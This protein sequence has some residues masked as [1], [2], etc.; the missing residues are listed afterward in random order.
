MTLLYWPLLHT[1]PMPSATPLDVI[2][3]GAG[4]AGIGT[5]YRLQE[6][7]PGKTY[8]IL[9]A[10]DSLG[11]TWDLFRYPG[12][13]SDSD[14]FT[15]GYR[16][17]PWQNPQS[18]SAGEDILTYLRETAEENGIDRHIRYG[19]RVTGAGWSS[20]DRLW[21]VTV[22]GSAGNQEVRSR[23][24]YLCTG[25]YD[26][27]RAHRPEFPGEKDFGGTILH[28]QFWPDDLDYTGQRI[29]VVGS[30]ATAMTLVPALAERAAHVTLL[31][32]SPTY[33]MTLPNRNGIYHFLSGR[34]PD[35]WAYRITRWAN[36]GIGMAMFGLSRLFPEG[37]R[38]LLMSGVARQVGPKVDVARHFNPP[39]RPWDQ[40][41]CLVPDGDLFR[42]L[43]EERATVVTDHIDR[44]TPTGIRLRSGLELTADLVVA[45]TGLKVKILGGATISLDGVV[46][47][48]TTTMI[49]K[50]TLV[51]GVPNLALAFGYTNASWTLKTDLTATYFCQLLRHMDREGYTT[52]VPQPEADVEARPFLDLSAGYIQRAKHTLPAQGSRRPWRVYQNYLLDA[53]MTR[54]GRIRDGVLKFA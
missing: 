47:E 19:H 16:F 15:F 39:Y 23:F 7:C 46:V 32:R 5:A 27:D 26:Y 24:L 38:R 10:R 42:V 48:P 41:L 30:G 22:E 36:L 29:V 49:Y 52:F 54:Y 37:A 50:G 31:Q 53:L 14:M 28:P 43:R 9:E 18:L 44:F 3:V 25:Y 33:V 12:I 13:R 17:R 35:R 34:V 40:R 21:T 6:R 4:L 11:G 45:A 51:S 20:E 8:A 1:V 2:I